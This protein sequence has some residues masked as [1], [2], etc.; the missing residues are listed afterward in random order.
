[1]PEN[2]IDSSAFIIFN[3][4]VVMAM[5]SQILRSREDEFLH[6]PKPFGTV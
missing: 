2:I 5:Q 6:P 3:R 4:V 1:M